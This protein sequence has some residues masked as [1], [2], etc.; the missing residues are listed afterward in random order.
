MLW[1]KLL[2]CSH[3]IGLERLTFI[4]SHWFVRL[5]FTEV[6]TV[7]EGVE[8]CVSCDGEVVVPC[9]GHGGGVAGVGVGYGSDGLGT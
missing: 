2:H 3:G 4:P 6:G 5:R 9:F 1:N 7:E 8:G